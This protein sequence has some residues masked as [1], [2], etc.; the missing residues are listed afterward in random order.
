VWKNQ[1]ETPHIPKDC[2]HCA[3]RETTICG[4]I[5]SDQLDILQQFKSSDRIVPAQT[6]LYRAGER[7]SEIYNLLSGWV[8]LYRILESGRRQIL[9][10]VRPGA[11]LAYQARLEDQMS[12]S[13]VCI[14][15][16]A[17]CIFPRRAFPALLE[18][19]PAL[20]LRLAGMLAEEIAAGQDQLTNIGGRS[21]IER[22]AYFILQIYLQQRSRQAAANSGIVTI[23]MT[24]E[25]I[26]D[27]L[28]ITQV[29]INRILRQ[30]RERQLAVLHRGTLEVLDLEGLRRVAKASEVAVA[31]G[32]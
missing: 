14:S 18:R 16:V 3:I 8:A 7:P 5:R 2:S 9:Q 32:L 31:S 29:H 27:A 12:H 19:H 15:D 23:P 6:H 30:L 20:Q 22:V 10:I 25:I 1:A 17:V 26:G 11:F 13:A 21:G 24:Q 4:A 28:G